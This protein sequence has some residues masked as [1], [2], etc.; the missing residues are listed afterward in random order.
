MSG[1][2]LILKVRVRSDGKLLK[3]P[4]KLPESIT[5]TVPIIPYIKCSG[6]LGELPRVTYNLCKEVESFLDL[7]LLKNDKASVLEIKKQSDEHNFV[8]ST[9]LLAQD[10]V[11][12]GLPYLDNVDIL[13]KCKTIRGYKFPN[14]KYGTYSTGYILN[15][16]AGNPIEEAQL[17]ADDMFYISVPMPPL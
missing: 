12:K 14:S 10:F 7:C 6:T 9:L 5:L 11:E 17:N 3:A 1:F 16:I 4:C 2:P 15:S 13:N 8:I